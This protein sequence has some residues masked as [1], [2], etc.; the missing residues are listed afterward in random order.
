MLPGGGRGGGGV[1]IVSCVCRPVSSPQVP[2]GQGPLQRKGSLFVP[3]EKGEMV[4]AD[5]YLEELARQDP[6]WRQ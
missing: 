4:P 1:R 5:N 3:Y 2:P 6:K